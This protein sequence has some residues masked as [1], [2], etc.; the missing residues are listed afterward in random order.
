MITQADARE[1]IGIN[2]RRIR[3]RCGLTQIQLSEA[4]NVDQ[5]AISR[6]ERGQVIP[7]AV[8]FANIAE[9]LDTSTEVLLRASS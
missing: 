5:G 1:F 8:D 3:Q 9:A 2:V 7:N 4:A 6:L